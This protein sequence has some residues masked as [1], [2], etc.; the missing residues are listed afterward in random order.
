[1]SVWKQRHYDGPLIGQQ[2]SQGRKRQLSVCA[3]SI[4]MTLYITAHSTTLPLLHLHHKRFIYVTRTSPTSLGEQPMIL[5]Y[6]NTVLKCSHKFYLYVLLIIFS[7]STIVHFSHCYALLSF[8]QFVALWHSF[9]EQH[10]FP[11]NFSLNLFYWWIFCILLSV[12]LRECRILVICINNKALF[13][14]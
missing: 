2:A 12:C 1:M 9:A 3:H 10:L 14:F 7:Y 6:P 5:K 13:H 8:F 11:L 4:W